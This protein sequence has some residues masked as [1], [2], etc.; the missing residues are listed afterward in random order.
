M[1]EQTG[2][3][4]IYNNATGY[5]EYTE[6]IGISTDFR[7]KDVILKEVGYFD[8]QNDKTNRFF[9]AR[10]NADIHMFNDQI[11]NE[12]SIMFGYNSKNKFMFFGLGTRNRNTLF[13]ELRTHLGENVNLND[14]INP[15]RFYC[16]LTADAKTHLNTPVSQDKMVAYSL[17][18]Y[19]A[20]GVIQ[21]LT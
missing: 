13:F 18:V 21:V 1:D 17:V 6:H 7:D 19:R 16:E 20:S 15:G 2:K 4:Y 3:L 10:S 11:E 9:S 12:K 14:V 5:K 8:P